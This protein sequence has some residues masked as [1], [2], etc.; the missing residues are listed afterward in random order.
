V[1]VRAVRA[2]GG[3]GCVREDD[4]ER[5]RRIVGITDQARPAV[6]E[7]LSSFARAWRHVLGTLTAA[8]QRLVVETLLAYEAAVTDHDS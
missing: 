6:S 2:H 4:D 7:W 8:E 3:F 5:R 1:I